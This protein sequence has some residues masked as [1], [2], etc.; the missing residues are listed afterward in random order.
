MAKSS[1][2]AT[3]LLEPDIGFHLAVASSR[4]AQRTNQALRRHGLRVRHYAVLALACEHD[5]MT[6]VNLARRVDL[7]ASQVVAL[8]DDLE[9]RGL[10]RRQVASDDRRRRLITA[11]DDGHALVAVASA[12]VT[13]VREEML[14]PLDEA[15]RAS[16]LAC[17]QILSGHG[18]TDEAS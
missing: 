10:I 5:G 12:D 1:A 8:I 17:A 3:S 4:I 16:L 11:T 13:R 18:H 15:Q 7:A 14:A 2:R 6:Q 9:D